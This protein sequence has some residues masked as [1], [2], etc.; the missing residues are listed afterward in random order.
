MNTQEFRDFNMEDFDLDKMT[1]SMLRNDLYNAVDKVK[2]AFDTSRDDA[3]SLWPCYY[4]FVDDD[5]DDKNSVVDCKVEVSYNGYMD[6]VV[7]SGTEKSFD[8]LKDGKVKKIR[9]RSLRRL[10]RGQRYEF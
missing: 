6:R 4:I 8:E 2:K 10:R 5:E 9:F 3:V 1:A 7:G